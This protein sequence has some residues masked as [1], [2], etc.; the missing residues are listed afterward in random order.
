MKIGN[1]TLTQDYCF[2][3][4]EAGVNHN[5]DLKLAKK[6]V[7]RAAEA[8]ADCVKFQTF[9][10]SELVSENAPKAKYQNDTTD[11]TESQADML[12]KLELSEQDFIE[13]KKECDRHN[14]MFMSTPFDIQS[15]N[16]LNRIGV[17]AFKIPSSEV[18]NIPFI[19]YL[20]GFK[21]PL[22][23]STGM[24]TIGDVDRLYQELVKLKASFCFLHCVSE[25]PSPIKDTNLRAMHTMRNAFGVPVG[26]SDHT[27]GIHIP[28]A[29]AALGAQILE[30]HFTLDRDMEG[31]DHRASIE[32]QE[33]KDMVRQVRHTCVALGNGIKNPSPIEVE[34]S[35]ASRKSLVATKDLKAGDRIGYDNLIA[36]RPGT[37]IPPYMFDDVNCMRLTKGLKKDEVL[38]ISHL[39]DNLTLTEEKEYAKRS[40]AKARDRKGS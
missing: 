12:R 6:L 32:P 38:T 18:T 39:H 2:I 21:K 29:A 40:K 5:G 4:A 10:T 9:K 26:Y 28:V 16:L 3:I 36:K 31:P 15:A 27:K 8:K 7:Q 35:K 25:Y 19:K 37:G 14:I 24:C 17:D 33:L 30:K 1:R 11:P 22:L 23:I 20:A 34:N 13:L